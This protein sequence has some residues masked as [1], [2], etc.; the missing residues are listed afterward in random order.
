MK[1]NFCEIN[2]IRS[3]NLLNKELSLIIGKKKSFFDILGIKSPL[4]RI[5]FYG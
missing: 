1:I 3:I 2:T 4:S 5:I